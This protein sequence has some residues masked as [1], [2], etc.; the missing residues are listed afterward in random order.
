MSG[1]AVTVPL[2]VVCGGTGLEKG[3]LVSGVNGDEALLPSN[4]VG[5]VEEEEAEEMVGEVLSAVGERKGGGT[6]E[7]EGEEPVEEGDVRSGRY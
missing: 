4:V 1:S 7:V 5:L 6:G 2:Q 3:L